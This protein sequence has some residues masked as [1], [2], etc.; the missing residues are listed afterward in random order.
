MK[1]MKR[2]IR[3][4]V[5]LAIAI[6]VTFF[7]FEIMTLSLRTQQ[8][9]SGWLQVALIVGLLLFY[10]KKKLSV[11]PLGKV[12]TWAQWHYYSG[13]FLIAVF[14]IH[15]E[16][17]VP[18][19]NVEI[20]LTALFGLVVCVGIIGAVINRVFARRLCYLGEEVIFERIGSHM[21]KLKER[22]E[23]QVLESVEKSNSS[24][25]SDYY[26]QH[27]SSYFSNNK[28]LFSHLIGRRQPHLKRVRNLQSQMR[29]L[30][31]QEA[32]FA[33]RLSKF[34]EQKQRL[35]NHYALQ[36]ALKYWGVLHAPI[37][38]LMLFMILVHIVL[39]Y[40]FRGA[41]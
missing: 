35:D 40:A 10:V 24:T 13:F 29:Y 37:S 8:Y 15:V 36:G 14:L 27:L 39:V 31:S 33:V 2:R 41:A 7:V 30:N 6:V 28:D 11:V 16:F 25:L 19:G 22:V 3:N 20:I 23:Q 5:L 4:T 21:A 1:F 32:E 17:S 18:D 34:I 26:I 38:L 12:A 9:S